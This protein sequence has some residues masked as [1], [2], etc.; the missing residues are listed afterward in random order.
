MSEKKH[1]ITDLRLAYNGPL[2][3]E[4]YY[5]EVEKWMEELGR[6]KDLKRKS[7]EVTS[8]G[9]K[10]EWIVEAWKEVRH[11][12]RHVVRLRTLFN[13]VEE[14]IIKKGNKRLRI[15]QGDIL[16]NIDG[17]VETHLEYHWSQKP[18]FQFFRTIFDKYIWPIGMTETERNEGPVRDECYGLHKRL[19]AFLSLYKMKVL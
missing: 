13:N 14:R 12:V 8:K 15:N 18:L 6:N 17:F 4:E 9:R 11:D 10:V 16:I 5:A 2:S 19:E 1:I 7:E 3:V